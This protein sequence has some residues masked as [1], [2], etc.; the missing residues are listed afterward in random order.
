MDNDDFSLPRGW[1]RAELLPDGGSPFSAKTGQPT[2]DNQPLA[3][4]PT[5][6]A[7]ALVR[8]DY[9]PIVE[10]LLDGRMQVS[11]FFDFVEWTASMTK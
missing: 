10:A 4:L 7:M 9:D 2:T 3:S 1:G 8:W 5:R 6:E 11:R